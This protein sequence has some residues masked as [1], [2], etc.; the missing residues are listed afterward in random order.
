[1]GGG[2]VCL[3]RRC[4]NGGRVWGVRKWRSGMTD[5]CG[6]GK[7]GSRCLGRTVASSVQLPDGYKRR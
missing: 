2:R 5:G 6:E 7:R 3:G 4:E 1:M